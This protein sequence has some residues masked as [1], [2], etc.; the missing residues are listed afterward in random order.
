MSAM[1]LLESRRQ[2]SAFVP[3]RA[4]RN[5]QWVYN[6]QQCVT[7][8]PDVMAELALLIGNVA[9]HRFRLAKA[10]IVIGRGAKSDILITDSTV[11]SQH[12]RLRCTLNKHGQV[13]SVVFEDLESTNGSWINNQ[14]VMTQELLHGDIIRIGATQ[15][16]FI[17]ETP[18]DTHTDV[19]DW[20]HV[21]L[22]RKL[23]RLRLDELSSR[24][25]EVLAL[26]RFAHRFRHGGTSGVDAGV[27]REISADSE[28]TRLLRVADTADFDT[29]GPPDRRVFTVSVSGGQ[30][31]TRQAI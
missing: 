24:E 4:K 9:I 3:R 5:R 14:P 10:E 17:H 13:D 30:G 15:L 22:R 6:S 12:A 8:V 16:K 27:K 23:D 2:R 20:G 1:S 28:P 19:G 29:V 18:D 31:V 26:A 21:E 11:S 7:E 25:R